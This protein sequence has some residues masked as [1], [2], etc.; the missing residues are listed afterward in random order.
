M[1]FGNATSVSLAIGLTFPETGLLVS[2]YV[3]TAFWL[4]FIASENSLVCYEDMMLF[5]PAERCY[6]V[7][8]RC[9][10]SATWICWY[11]TATWI[12]CYSVTSIRCYSI[13]WICCCYTSTWIY[14]YSVTWICCYSPCE[15]AIAMFCKTDMFVFYHVNML[16]W[17]G[18]NPPQVFIILFV[19]NLCVVCHVDRE[20][21]RFSFS[22]KLSLVMLSNPWQ[23]VV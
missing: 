9:C 13:T 19:S 20:Y 15:Y 23:H 1:L 2:F 7:T 18:Y 21:V 10:Y 14:F 6:S 3:V 5:V 16:S 22:L 11:Y 12:C 4:M 17:Y 8:L